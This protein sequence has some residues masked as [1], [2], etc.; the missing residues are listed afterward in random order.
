VSDEIYNEVRSKIEK[1]IETCDDLKNNTVGIQNLKP[2]AQ[3]KGELARLYY[4]LNDYDNAEKYCIDCSEIYEEIGAEQDP[5]YIDNLRNIALIYRITGRYKNAKEIY[6]RLLSFSNKMLSVYDLEKLPMVNM[7]ILLIRKQFEELYGGTLHDLA[8]IYFTLGDYDNAEKYC[9]DGLEFRRELNDDR[10]YAQSLNGMGAINFKRGNYEKAKDYYQRALALRETIKKEDDY[11]L[12]ESDVDPD[13]LDREIAGNYINLGNIY[14]AIFDD[15]Q[16]EQLYLKALQIQRNNLVN[17]H[18]DLAETFSNLAQIYFWR[19]DYENAE[20]YYKASADILEDTVGKIHPFYVSVLNEIAYLYQKI[21]KMSDAFECFNEAAKIEDK[22]I[23]TMF[24]MGSEKQRMLYMNDVN[25]HYD[26]FLSFLKSFELDSNSKAEIA[27]DLV[28]RRKGIVAESTAVQRNIIKSK[29]YPK[30]EPKLKEYSLLCQE[31]ARILVQVIPSEET[32]SESLR[33]KISE[34]DKLEEYLSSNIPEMKS[35]ESFLID[36]RSISQNLPTNAVLIEFVSI[37]NSSYIAFVLDK[38][39][40]LQMIDLD[41]ANVIDN[42]IVEFRRSLSRGETESFRRYGVELRRALLDPISTIFENHKQLL[43]APDGDLNMIPF[44][45]FPSFDGFGYL[46][47]EYHISYLST[48]KDILQ[49]NTNNEYK[50]ND[51]LIIGDPDFDLTVHVPSLQTKDSVELQSDQSL[52]LMSKSIHF[53]PLPETYEE[54]DHIA[55]KFHV[56][57]LTRKNVLESKLRE[58]ESPYILHLATHGFFLPNQ[59]HTLSETYNLRKQSALR[60]TS[61]NTSLANFGARIHNL[62]GERL[63]NPLI[64]SGLALAGVNT[65]FRKGS[66]PKEAEDGML[67]A[68]DVLSLNLLGTKLV[69]LSA[70]DTGLG[71]PARGEGIFGLRRS[72]LLSGAKSLVMSLWNVPTEYTKEMM[73]EFY[74]LL[75]AGRSRS[76]SLREAQ[77]SIRDRP[78]C[79]DPFIW[80]AF[81]CQGDFRPL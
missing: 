63:E 76:E 16:A 57:P 25:Y 47:D 65:W 33:D 2:L 53:P 31:I 17:N 18:P 43:I 55:K 12:S 10:R 6:E 48:G 37:S 62:V 74:D 26:R 29:K 49:I 69:V 46:I 64:R 68:F 75:L 45:I 77:L 70:C 23:G 66:L 36:I 34:K 1:T 19:R 4:I 42:L 3:C 27:Y 56:K 52:D 5:G 35:K 41:N 39:E 15:K 44:E 14:S 73:K 67:N 9:K 54:A 24:S 79:S 71:E 7:N 21:G 28:L 40:G 11:N 58:Y 78:G 32:F 30:L 60:S 80:G 20:K 72:F 59:E 81:I 38:S 13:N 61:F 8:G 22:I 51:P 50:Y